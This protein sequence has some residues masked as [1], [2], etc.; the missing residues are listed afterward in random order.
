MNDLKQLRT[1]SKEFSVLYVE[2]NEALRQN[3]FKLL[4]KFFNTVEIAQDGKEA[5]EKFNLRHYPLVITDIKMP[6][7]D[8]IT[9]TKYLRQI[10]T[11]TKIIILSAFDDKEYL[12]QALENKVFRFLK[13]PVKLGELTDVLYDVV[14]EMKQER[15]KKLFYDNLESIVSYQS[16]MVVMME[17]DEII[18]ANQ[19][20]LDFFRLEKISDFKEKFGE[21][22][23]QF[24][25]HDGFLFPSDAVD[26]LAKL[27]ETQKKLFHVKLK[28]TKHK[29]RHFIVKY[30]LIPKK[31]DHGILSFDDITE[32]NLLKLFDQNETR[33]DEQLQDRKVL[34]DL[35]EVVKRNSGKVTAHNYYK[36]LSVTNDAL[37]DEIGKTSLRIKTTYLQEKGIQVEQKTIL[38]SE[39]FPFAIECSDVSKMSFEKQVIEFNKFRFVKSSPIMRKTVR[40]VPEEKHS[41]S[42]FVGENKFHGDVSIE[43][44]SLD[45]VRLKL[46]AIPAGLDVG[47]EVTLDIVLEMNK[48]PFIFHTKATILRKEELRHS[49]QLVLLFM[50][51]KKS[52]LIKYISTRQMAIIR[53]F[54]GMQNG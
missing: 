19:V 4:Q 51:A 1:L 43:D 25:E 9:F 6:K 52:D 33:K 36:G 18:F 38:S 5:L 3:V 16:S 31:R 2:D 49:F 17:R 50:E 8:G 30:Q 24:L 26:C 34:L 46:N 10:D 45:A 44:L 21:L 12:F 20:F 41:V 47:Y 29:F 37:M 35:L 48:R 42:M 7:M 27:Q 28:D 14:K 15:D 54:K 11:S 40:V 22:S 23:S 32:L 13:K 53:E 39:V